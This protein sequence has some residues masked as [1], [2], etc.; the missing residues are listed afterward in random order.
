MKTI[1][2]F[3]FIQSALMWALMFCVLIA[4]IPLGSNRPVLWTLLSMAITTLFAVQV[5]LDSTYRLPVQIKSLWLPV[6]LFLGAAG[7][8]FV[9]TWPGLPEA[10]MHPAWSDLAS[11]AADQ[12]I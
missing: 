2:L 12:Q 7:W 5:A 6:A 4:A 1:E 3:I 8:G 10:F 11:A 9:Q